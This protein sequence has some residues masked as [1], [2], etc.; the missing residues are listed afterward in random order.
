MDE[1]VE[2]IKEIKQE[3]KGGQETIRRTMQTILGGLI[4]GLFLLAANLAFGV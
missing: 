4:V 2:G 3:V 1:I